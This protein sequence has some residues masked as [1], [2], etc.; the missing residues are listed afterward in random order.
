MYAVCMCI[1]QNTETTD[2]QLLIRG[3]EL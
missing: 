3:L 1:K 2:E